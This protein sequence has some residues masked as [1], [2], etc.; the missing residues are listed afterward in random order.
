[1][2]PGWISLYFK[3][4]HLPYIPK[5]LNSKKGVWKNFADYCK[6]RNSIP[7]TVL[8]HSYTCVAGVP[9][10]FLQSE[11]LYH[12]IWPAEPVLSQFINSFTISYSGGKIPQQAESPMVCS[13]DVGSFL[14]N[15]REKV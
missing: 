8:P 14:E 13:R 1:M 10:I 12:R 2:I 5:C 6:R 7:K 11:S 15:L 9:L 3:S 4:L